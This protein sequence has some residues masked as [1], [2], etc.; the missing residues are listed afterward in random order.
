MIPVAD[1]EEEALRAT[2][3][4]APV[5]LTA[6]MRWEARPLARG[7]G[8]SGAA[9]R[10]EGRVGGRR[11]VLVETGLGAARTRETLER[12]P[13]AADFGVAISA[14][15][16]GAMQDGVRCGDVVADVHG[17]EAERVAALRAAALASGVALHFGRILHT[18]VVLAPAAKRRL[19][20]EQRAL[21]CDMETAAV[22]RWAAGLVPAFGVRAV[23]DE[24]DDE[25]PPLPD[26]DGAGALLR[27]ALSRP[28]RLPLLARTG[29][30][31][32]RAM[33][34]LARLLRTYLEAA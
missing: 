21:A 24:V 3:P 14:G 10:F 4:G 17:V 2:G 18:N 25:L 13:A 20:A 1:P 9:G 12:G 6:A 31:S 34:A 30:R 11:V 23:L 33:R 28:A 8:L 7:L 22:R 15:L 29:R 16:C 19:G 27:Y 32:A 5:L 26:G